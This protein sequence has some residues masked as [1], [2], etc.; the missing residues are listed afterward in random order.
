MRELAWIG[1]LY[2][3]LLRAYPKAFRD[4]YGSEMKLVFGD[5]LRDASASNQR[6]AV[7]G[8]C[9]RT[10]TD[11]VASVLRER[12]AAAGIGGWLLMILAV[13]SA[14]LFVFV[15]SRATEVQAP[16]LIL[17]CAGFLLGAFAGRGWWRWAIALGVLIPLLELTGVRLGPPTR[18]VIGDISVCSP[19]ARLRCGRQSLEQRSVI[20]RI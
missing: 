8:V 4:E 11:L 15:N 16:A 7:A 10:L 6:F 9:I 3:V 12:S 14:A 19:L 17:V 20:G 18:P 5:L 1:A 2:G 13:T